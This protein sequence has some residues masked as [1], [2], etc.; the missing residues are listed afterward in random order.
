[1]TVKLMEQ[2]EQSQACLGYAESR[3]RKTEGLLIVFDFDGTLGDTRRNI[4]VTMQDVMR[5]LGLPMQDE[6]TCAATIGLPLR[7][8][9]ATMFPDLTEY[10]LDRCAESH[11][12]HFNENLK[13]ITPV[14]F[15]HVRETLELLKAK[16]RTLAIASSRTS[17]SLHDLLGRMDM[18]TFFSCIVGAED[19]IHAKPEAEP[20]LKILSKTGF[21]ADETLVVG[22]MDVDILM[23]R[24]AGARTCGVTYGNGSRAELDAAGADYIID[25]MEQI[26]EIVG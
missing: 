1:M 7:R 18:G 2:R 13:K 21:I 9:Y 15:P 16:E 22:D 23:G 8:C 25:S 6:S 14:P 5:E 20:V 4:V 3:Q 19:V 26:M 24:N 12:V 11:R 10:E 17:V